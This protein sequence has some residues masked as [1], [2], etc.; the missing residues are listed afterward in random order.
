[1]AGADE[2]IGRL[3]IAV[4]YE[5]AMGVGDGLADAQEEATTGGRREALLLA[6]AVDGFAVD[7]FED[8]ERA[9]VGGGA[10]VE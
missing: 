8:E 10:S 7:I 2:D 1:M 6:I 3:E 5:V 9:T 4:D